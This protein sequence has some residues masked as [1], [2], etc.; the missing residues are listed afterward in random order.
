MPNILDTDSKWQVGA[1]RVKQVEHNC[2]M[3]LCIKKLKGK[4]YTDEKT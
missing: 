1:N 3:I 4:Y 2:Q